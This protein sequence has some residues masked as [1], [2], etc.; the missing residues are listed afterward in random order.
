MLIKQE[1]AE[2]PHDHHTCVQNALKQADAVTL[3]NGV[4][5][6][7]LRRRVL[8]IVWRSHAAMKAYDILN[9]LDVYI[10]SAKPPTVYRALQ[11]LQENGLVHRLDSLNA[12]IG[13]AHPSER[14]S[15]K[16]FICTLCGR[17][18]EFSLDALQALVH[19][20]ASKANFQVHR[21]SLEVLG[22]CTSCAPVQDTLGQGSQGIES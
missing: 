22:C 18:R 7:E 15:G 4:R 13:C 10:G 12:Y 16:F 11:F 6:T 17:V 3:R 20:A 9:Q 19:E 21:Q 8:E 5:L 14:H 1:D 2:K